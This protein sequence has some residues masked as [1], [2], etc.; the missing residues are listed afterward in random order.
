M[1]SAYQTKGDV[2]KAKE[3]YDSV[4]KSNNK[5][6]KIGRASCRERV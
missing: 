2:K 4:I 6:A 1:A 5:Y 3:I